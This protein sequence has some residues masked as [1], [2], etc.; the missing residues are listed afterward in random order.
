MADF[1]YSVGGDG[2]YEQQEGQ[3][4]V[5]EGTELQY[6]LDYGRAIQEQES[7]VLQ[8]QQRYSTVSAGNRL[9]ATHTHTQS[10]LVSV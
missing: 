8:N 2:G 9:E 7:Y 5:P 3:Q 10:Q 1:T 4:W 6:Y